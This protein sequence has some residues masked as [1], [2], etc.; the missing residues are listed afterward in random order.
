MYERAIVELEL[1]VF[2]ATNN[3]PIWR[4]EGNEAQADSCREHAES[5][6]AAIEQLKGRINASS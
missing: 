5:C 1:A 4:A 2:N 3:E 6:Q